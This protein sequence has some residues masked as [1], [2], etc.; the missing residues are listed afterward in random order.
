MHT[1]NVNGK[2]A[3]P[4]SSR[5]MGGKD[6]PLTDAQATDIL[7]WVFAVTDDMPG[8]KRHDFDPPAGAEEIVIYQDYVPDF[9]VI[10]IVNG[11]PVA[12][13]MPLD[14]LF[15]VLSD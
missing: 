1:R 12:A 15:R 7:C 4:E 6:T 2:T 8:A 3:A 9:S 10:W 13:A 5:K 11:W 14:S